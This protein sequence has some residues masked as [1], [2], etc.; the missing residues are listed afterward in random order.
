MSDSL[1][2]YELYSLPGSSVQGII[3][4][5]IPEL[6]AI[7]SSRGSSQPRD[8]TQVS[9]SPALAGGL[10]TTRATWEALWWSPFILNDIHASTYDK[11]IL[12]VLVAIISKLNGV[13]FV[14]N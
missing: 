14:S 9:L 3:Q 7:S 11:N 8:Q 10:F 13:A 1:Q 4:A 12:Q 5:R 2:L 6:V